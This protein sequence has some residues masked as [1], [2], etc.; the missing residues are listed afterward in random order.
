MFVVQNKKAFIFPLRFLAVA[1][2]I[3]LFILNF[4]YTMLFH[5]EHYSDTTVWKLIYQKD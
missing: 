1:L 5:H 4:F 3:Y 2:I